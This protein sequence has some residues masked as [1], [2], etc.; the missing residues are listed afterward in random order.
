MFGLTASLWHIRMDRAAAALESGQP[1]VTL[2]IADEFDRMAAIVD[3]VAWPDMLRLKAEAARITD[4]LGLTRRTYQE[5][6][7]L[8]EDANGPGVS[9]RAQAE[10][11]LAD[12]SGSQTE[13]M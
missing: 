11:A 13:R 5:L 1:E 4:N 6:A 10:S 7:E 8:L 2:R 9:L 12:L 3:Q